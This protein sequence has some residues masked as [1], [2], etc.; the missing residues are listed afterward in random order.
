[1]MCL[2]CSIPSIDPWSVGSPL[3]LF[4]NNEDSPYDV[5]AGPSIL[6]GI[7]KGGSHEIGEKRGGKQKE[8][9]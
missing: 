2:G 3:L 6:Y 9:N 1:M 5:N 4:S 7:K 8:S